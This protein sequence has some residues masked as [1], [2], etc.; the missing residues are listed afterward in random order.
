MRAD[1][2]ASVKTMRLRLPFAFVI[3]AVLALGALQL[4][5]QSASKKL[6]VYLAV[7]K[8]DKPTTRFSADVPMICAFW[9]GEGLETGDKL[10]VVWIAEE[11]GGAPPKQDTIREGELK[12]Y[13]PDEDGDFSLSRPPGKIWPVGKYAVHIYLNDR[14]IE[15]IHFAIEPGVKIE[16]H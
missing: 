13:R 7:N 10:K 16:V 14:P 11:I 1:K 2:C 9:K 5:G 4:I 8:T 6:H 15:L 12:V 3:V